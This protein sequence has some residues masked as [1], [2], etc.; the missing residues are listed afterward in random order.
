MW[1]DANPCNMDGVAGVEPSLFIVV[2]HCRF[3]QA[4]IFPVGPGRQE[5]Q[6]SLL[7]ISF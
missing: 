4:M 2:L 1:W 3:I 7:P 6:V 5:Y